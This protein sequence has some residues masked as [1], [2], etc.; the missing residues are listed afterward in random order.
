MT[1]R[2]SP[3]YRASK[4]E[5]I[6]INKLHSYKTIYYSHNRETFYDSSHFILEIHCHG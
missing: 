2:T 6:P 5:T 3:A 1:K 4:E